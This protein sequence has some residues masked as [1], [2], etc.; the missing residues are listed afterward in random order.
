MLTRFQLKWWS[1]TG[2]DPTGAQVRRT[3]GSS[4]TPDSSKKTITA[5]RRRAFLP[6]PRPV[7]RNPAADRR[8]VALQRASGGALQAP[9]HLP[10]HPPDVPGMVAHAGQP[11][12][13]LRDPLQRPPVG[14]EAMRTSA[15]AQ[16]LVDHGAL[17]SRQL[18]PAALA[19]SA[20]QRRGAAGSPAGVP[21][22]GGLARDLKDACHCR[23]RG[24]LVEQLGG[25]QATLLE[26]CQVAA[27]VSKRDGLVMTA[28]RGACCL[29]RRSHHEHMLPVRIAL[30]N[31]IRERLLGPAV[32]GGHDHPA[33]T[34]GQGLESARR[35][36]LD[37]RRVLLHLAE[38]LANDSRYRLES[39]AMTGSLWGYW[40]RTSTKACVATVVGV[41]RSQFAHAPVWLSG[42]SGRRS[43]EASWWSLRVSHPARAMATCE[44]LR[45]RRPMS[46]NA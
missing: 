5:L 2:V 46:S 6:D 34:V 38:A 16:C 4:E 36:P 24:T 8:L 23:L 20:G 25:A 11:L 10:Q 40:L 3:T 28:H 22:A 26:P 7:L 1:S 41:L 13:H 27:P 18:W 37:E 45:S 15:L 14:R 12:D 21:H 32:D 35:G 42:P 17:F 19:A 31:L 43:L 44:P 29:D 39:A 30:I 9:A 33:A